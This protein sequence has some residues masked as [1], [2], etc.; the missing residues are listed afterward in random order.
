MGVRALSPLSSRKVSRLNRRDQQIARVKERAERLREPP[1]RL[2]SCYEQILR[3][4]EAESIVG[5]V[6][7]V[8]E[9]DDRTPSDFRVLTN[10]EAR[11]LW[12]FN[13]QSY[14]WDHY[15]WELGRS[16]ALGERTYIFEELRSVPATEEAIDATQPR[17]GAV[18]DA[19]AE[20][21]LRGYRPD[22]VCAPIDL[23]VPFNSDKNLTIDWNSSPRE[24]LIVPGGP[25]LKIFW[26]SRIAP[27]DRFVV[28]D[29]KR[30]VWRV[31][32]DPK[33]GHRLT[34]AIGEPETPPDAVVFL[35]ETVVKFEIT[36][37]SAFRAILLEGEPKP[38][39]EQ[40]RGG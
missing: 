13:D 28:L 39:E 15:C 23:F 37:S 17:F 1:G 2:E 7:R 3:A 8:I 5:H 14:H 29:S 11:H 27:V 35:A 16:I 4:Y 10:S 24:A 18:L 36:D 26:S 22:V 30:A 38:L 19:I 31:K 34:V 12:Q 21:R 25:P 33:T 9:E 40:A 32:L 6:A 20:L